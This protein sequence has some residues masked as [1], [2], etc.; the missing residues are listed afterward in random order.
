MPKKEQNKLFAIPQNQNK[1]GILFIFLYSL[2]KVTRGLIAI[3]LYSALT[4]KLSNYWFYITLGL[5]V[6]FLTV[7]VFSYLSY[8]NFKFH[9]DYKNYR[10]VLKQGVFSTNTLDISL[11]RIQQVYVKRTIIHRII[12]V[13][14]LVVE[15][16]GSSDKEIEIKALSEDKALAL[17]QE[18]LALKAEEYSV[19][20][21][22]SND[23]LKEDLNENDFKQAADS[24]S[25]NNVEWTYKL[26]LKKLL[27]LGLTSN[28][29]RGLGL[30]IVFIST[31]YGQF[32]QFVDDNAYWK[33]AEEYL[34]KEYT[35]VFEITLVLVLSFFILFGLSILVSIIETILKYFE[36]KITKKKESLEVEMGLKTNTKWSLNPNRVQIVTH[37]S[38]PLQSRFDLHQLQLALIGSDDQIKKNSLS[39]PA[40]TISKMQ[41]IQNFLF[42]VKLEKG[43][44]VRMYPI[45]LVKRLVIITLLVV[46]VFFLNYF[47]GWFRIELLA[48]I[49]ILVGL[50]LFTLQFFIFRSSKLAITPNFVIKSEGVWFKK[51][52][53]IELYKIQAF[54]VH[55]PI[56]LR[57]RKLVHITFHTAAGD[58]RFNYLPKRYCARLN[59]LLYRVESSQQAWM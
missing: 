50:I 26:G 36:V 1:L 23:L 59:Y 22:L 21:E 48:S 27:L 38:N 45:W 5:S 3:F 35:S 4:Q 58:L 18:L 30:I 55:E 44:F 16:A 41:Q 17:Q 43:E 37:S 20:K 42:S 49:L 14:S 51:R 52:K 10:F 46:G 53:Y 15:S 24:I 9:I 6:L 7:L 47:V 8:K 19:I 39:I 31:V 12:G 54:S 40:L 57:K 33:G 34:E 56:F 25:K 11:Q 2:Y 32:S 13:C 28:Y 29:F